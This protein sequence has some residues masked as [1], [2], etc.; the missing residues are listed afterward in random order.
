[1][2]LCLM[3]CSLLSCMPDKDTVAAPAMFNHKRLPIKINGTTE[4]GINGLAITSETDTSEDIFAR[5]FDKGS[6]RIRGLDIC[7]Y[8]NGY[9]VEK[10]GWGPF[11]LRDLP[12]EDICIYNIESR[13]NKLDSPAIGSIVVRYFNDPN[14]EPLKIKMNGV[15]RLGVNWVQLKASE[16]AVRGE[17]Q[18]S[19]AGIME[20]RDITIYPSSSGKVIITG[21]GVK[22]MVY[23]Y[24][25]VWSTT[26]DNLYKHLGGVAK[27]C[28]F[29][30]T[31]NNIDALKESATILVSTYRD[32]GGF[33]DAPIVKNDGK[34][35]CFEF[36]DMYVVG[37]RVN[38][39]IVKNWNTKKLCVDKTS[40]YEVE[41]ITSNLRLFYGIHNGS[42]WVVVK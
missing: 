35:K 19:N 16:I 12:E 1:M 25:G 39:K 21:C 33:L 32:L 40:Y 22:N 4:I 14:V 13:A 20:N 17:S 41:G 31:A 26:V 5:S 37:L 23:D 3:S 15:E 18:K 36:T 38:N 11:E 30:I 6:L 34:E 42:E 29:T 9:G 2:L 8:V 7:G 28:V 10:F 27:D 24:N